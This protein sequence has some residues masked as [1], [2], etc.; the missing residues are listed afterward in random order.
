MPWPPA[1]APPQCLVE[2][3]M[4]SITRSVNLPLLVA[5]PCG[6]CP[7]SVLRS[8]LVGIAAVFNVSAFVDIISEL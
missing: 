8:P 7:M 6:L 3:E 4:G 1:T 2:A 5:G